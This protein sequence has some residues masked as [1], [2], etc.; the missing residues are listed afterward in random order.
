M[1]YDPGSRGEYTE[2]DDAQQGSRNERAI[3]RD[4]RAEAQK[5]RLQKQRE[6][7]A[8]QRAKRLA[9]LDSLLEEAESER[10]LAQR[11]LKE[12]ESRGADRHALG[13]AVAR[14]RSARGVRAQQPSEKLPPTKPRQ[15]PRRPQWSD[16][17]PLDADRTRK[18]PQQAAGSGEAPEL[19]PEHSE[20]PKT[21]RDASVRTKA[22]V[23]KYLE[24]QRQEQ[25]ERRAKEE[26][27][28]REKHER[29]QRQ[30][31]GF[32][33]QR[34]TVA[35]RAAE[36]HKREKSER[37]AA[38]AEEMKA[39]WLAREKAKKYSSPKKIAKLKAGRE[40]YETP[41]QPIE[42]QAEVEAP[43]GIS[44][45]AAKAIF[46]ELDQN[47]DGKISYSEL[48]MKM[49]KLDGELEKILGMKEAQTHSELMYRVYQVRKRFDT[50]DDG[51]ISRE[52]FVKL[53]LGPAGDVSP[54][55]QSPRSPEGDLSFEDDPLFARTV[56]GLTDEDWR[57][58]V[59]ILRPSGD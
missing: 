18:I 6:E 16:G 31:E 15:P 26:A 47:G 22:R 19:A 46:R 17:E 21:E 34:A 58:E 2:N 13:Q 44:E 11:R 55:Q 41:P 35:R 8:F 3:D 24:R 12:I 48:K 50:N 52:E 59:N 40:G 10:Y 45:A 36:R 7:E 37:E 42:E 23:K 51:Y 53:L 43:L 27:E 25:A 30:A 29:F 28:K 20:S 32:K 54:T 14:K 5:R 39:E 49:S 1:S 33:E 38:K 4:R 57:V 56:H 9:E